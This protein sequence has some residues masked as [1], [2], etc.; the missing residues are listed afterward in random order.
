[1]IIYILGTTYRVTSDM[2][3]FII[4]TMIF[5]FAFDVYED[6]KKTGIVCICLYVIGSII[7]VIGNFIYNE[8]IILELC[9]MDIDCKDLICERAMDEV[10]QSMVDMSSMRKRHKS[11]SHKS[12]SIDDSH[13]E[14]LLNEF[15]D[16]QPFS[17]AVFP[18]NKTSINEND[19][20]LSGEL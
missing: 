16:K 12:G 1:M 6:S 14:D 11:I 19:E 7:V 13:V 4:V 8:I 20:N 17:C 2:C 5:F 10:N 15:S 9:D 3:E 18:I